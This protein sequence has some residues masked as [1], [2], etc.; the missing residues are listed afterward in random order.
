MLGSRHCL[1]LRQAPTW[2]QRMADCGI[3]TS[4]RR[5]AAVNACA[6]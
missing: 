2:G 5:G 1:H 3:C 4:Y 6:A